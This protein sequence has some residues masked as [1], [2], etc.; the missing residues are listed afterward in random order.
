MLVSLS[1]CGKTNKDA[2]SGTDKRSAQTASG[3][4]VTFKDSLGRTV[5]VDSPKRVAVMLG[6]FADVWSLAGGKDTIAAAGNDAW[7][8]FDLG[9]GKDVVN[10]GSVM[11][12]D[13]ETL[14]SLDPD[15]VIASSNTKANVNMLETLEKAKINVAYFNVSNFESYLDMLNTCCKITGKPENYKK[16]GTDVAKQVED[17]KARVGKEHPSVLCIRATS[18]NCIAKSSKDNVLGE[19]LSNLGC[20]NIADTDSGILENLSMEAIIDK[21]PDFIFVI[22]HGVDED[23]AEGVFKEAYLNNPSWQNLTAVKNGNCHV[24]DSHLFDLKPNDRWGKAYEE[25]VDIL[26]PEES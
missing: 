5:T 9:L 6:S 18:S 1:A 13:V 26:Y 2:G 4:E 23:K 17:A 25:L 21:D 22:L 8:E 19:M 15:F 14:L 7:T 12:P 11:H 24:M 16:Y 3:T 10:L 20:V